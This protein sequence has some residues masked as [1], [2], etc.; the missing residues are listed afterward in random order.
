MREQQQA[1]TAT[2]RRSIP[3]V[4]PHSRQRSHSSP[5]ALAMGNQSQTQKSLQ[6]RVNQLKQLSGRKRKGRQSGVKQVQ[7][8][9]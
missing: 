3:V 8:N 9:N 7:F 5:P 2:M 1:A 6:A 4:N